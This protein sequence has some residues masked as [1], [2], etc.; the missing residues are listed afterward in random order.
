[1]N[2]NTVLITIA[3]MATMIITSCK[4]KAQ[5]EAELF[6]ERANIEFKNNQY[7]KALLI[8]DSLRKVYPTAIEV[9]K[10]ALKLQQSI[11]LK[12]AQEELALTDSALQAVIL[13][14]NYLHAKVEK[15][16]ELLRATEE[17]LRLLT[18]TR[19]K[20]DSLQVCFDEQCARIKYIH[21]K[22]KEI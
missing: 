2:R 16:K 15:D 13:N 1:M 5:Q 22:Q 7:S 12:Q 19:I 20:R 14:Y 8:I 3:I 21:K 17:E 18:L 9:R 11:S 10:Q 4:P 6:L